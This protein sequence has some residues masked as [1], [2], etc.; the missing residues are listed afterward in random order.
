MDPN[1]VFQKTAKGREEIEKRT[2]RVD[3]K[4]RTLLILVDGRASASVL[5]EKTAQMGDAF[6]LLQS[7]WSQGLVEPTGAAAGLSAAA[8]P[9]PAAAPPGLPTQAARAPRAS[10]SRS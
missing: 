5:A 8:A 6:E 9:A 7:L 3:A 2:L 10:L 1:L 4:R